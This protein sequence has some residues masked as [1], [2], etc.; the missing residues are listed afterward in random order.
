MSF[1]VRTAGYLLAPLLF[2]GMIPSAN[3]AQSSSN[4]TAYLETLLG[5]AEK[6][7]EKAIH[8]LRQR[9]QAYPQWHRGRLELARLYF[10]EGHY[11]AARKNVKK[12]VQKAP[13][14]APVKKN[15]L[16]FYRQIL[17]AEREQPE[18]QKRSP[19]WLLGGK[20]SAAY[21]YDSNANTGPEDQDIGISNVRLKTSALGQSDQYHTTQLLLRADRSLSDSVQKPAQPG[22]IRWRNR[23]S[24][25]ER[26]YTQQDSADIRSLQLIS[27]LSYQLT[28]D[29]KIGNRLRL[30][31]LSYGTETDINYAGLEPFAQWHQGKHRVRMHTFYNHRNYLASEADK[32]DGKVLELGLR[33]EYRP[34]RQGR[35]Q[36]G[37]RWYD[38]DYQ[39][40]RYSYQAWETEGQFNYRM[41]RA[42]SFW[43]QVRYRHREY[44]APET[45]H[46][47]DARDDRY[48][49]V[50][51]GSR[52][53]LSPDVA[54]E[55][56]I[57]GYRNKANHKLHEYN[58]RQAELKLSWQF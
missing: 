30:S 4:H 44:Q 37:T 22:F 38:A 45:P 57:S 50:R 52:Y 33:Y 5:Q 58:R 43:S 9:L 19:D 20:L 24:L 3:A 15:I 7:P 8:S 36:L 42:L 51:L 21:G 32:K 35:L 23:F 10:N 25:F 34:N 12:V 41:T 17:I 53:R 1:S 40:D 13:L 14:P 18:P 46:Y 2:A 56:A 29:W 39:D 55:L 47:N 48:L 49:T 6:Q 54:L 11:Q 28:S 26:N 31:R 27:G 16:A